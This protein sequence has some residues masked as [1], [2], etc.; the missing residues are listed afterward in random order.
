MVFG[1]TRS[2]FET[3]I[4]RTQG[5]HANHYTDTIANIMAICFLCRGETSSLRKSQILNRIHP[6][7]SGIRSQIV[8]HETKNDILLDMKTQ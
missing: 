7:T 2:G 1:F 3:T 4:Y 5:E 6:T 8:L